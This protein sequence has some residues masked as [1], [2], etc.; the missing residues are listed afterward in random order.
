MI[1]HAPVWGYVHAFGWPQ[2]GI[3]AS[4]T[5]PFRGGVHNGLDIGD[6]HC[7]REI[8]AAA[9]GVVVEQGL[10]TDGAIRVVLDHGGWRTWY[11]HL[12]DE[13]VSTGQRVA[14][15]QVLGHMGNTGHSFGCHLH[16]AIRQGYRYLD[17]WPRLEQNVT[18]RP[19]D[20]GVNIRIDE[21]MGAVYAAT[22]PDGLIHRA[23]D[24]APLGLTTAPRKWGGEVHGATWTVAGRTGDTWDRILLP[25]SSA[26]R[27]ICTALDWRS[28]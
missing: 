11:W 1:I 8:I 7:G 5:Q 6:G 12:R 22:K 3:D 9:D 18:V 10:A 4:V 27:Y 17:P 24:N 19:K 23:S 20:A 28:A 14:R 16:F 25:D 13:Q 21:H 2:N 26:Y 15:A